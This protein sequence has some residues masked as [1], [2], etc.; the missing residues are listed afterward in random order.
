MSNSEVS[1]VPDSVTSDINDCVTDSLERVFAQLLPINA[2]ACEAFHDAVE[3]IR[4]TPNLYRHA[5]GFLRAREESARAVSVF[6]ED[7]E[8][9]NLAQ[10]TEEASQPS[11]KVWSGGY[12]LSLRTPPRTP[13]EGWAL[14]TGNDVDILL[15]PPVQKWKMRRMAASHARLR[16]HPESRCITVQARHTVTISAAS[17]PHTFSSSASRVINDGQVLIIGDCIY[18]FRYTE[19]VKENVFAEELS[20]WMADHHGIWSVGQKLLTPISGADQMTLGVFTFSPGCFAQGTFG[21]LAAGWSSDGAAVAV[22]RFKEPNHGKLVSHRKI[23][24]H[25]GNHVRE[26]VLVTNIS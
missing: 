26:R 22:K 7:D 13:T 16:F 18:Q 25:I 9:S 21:Q 5:N 10:S 3:A 4:N 23:M 17:Q 1:T 8:A 15:A 12:V 24:D 19:V 20:R 2:S 6:T 11:P 14:G